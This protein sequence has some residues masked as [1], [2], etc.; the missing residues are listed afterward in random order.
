MHVPFLRSFR[1]GYKR[2]SKPPTSIPPMKRLPKLQQYGM[3][4]AFSLCQVS[5]LCE[6]GSA[7][8][9]SF[10]VLFVALF[11]LRHLPF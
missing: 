11:A 9:A 10:V 3:E 8:T 7:S 1:Q 6:I 5:L 2:V 4:W